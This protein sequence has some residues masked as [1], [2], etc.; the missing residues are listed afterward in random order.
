MHIFSPLE[1][2]KQCQASCRVDISIVSFLSRCHRAVTPI[3]VFRVGLRGD[4]RISCRGVRCIGSALQHQGPFKW[5]HDRWS[6]SRVS[7]GDHLLFRC[8]G[9]AGIIFPHEAGKWTL[10]LG[11]GGET[12]ALLKLW[13][14]PRR[15]SRVETG[16]SGNF[17]SCFKG[18]K[19][20]FEAQ[21]GRW[22]FS[23]DPTVEKSLI[24]H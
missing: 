23:R 8:D 22:D 1:L 15:S 3:I 12:T 10:L 13:W 6:S 19:D 7:S 4:R 5:W 2:E 24:S 11:G 21:E 18:V 17:L 14:D 9:N 20:P 16:M